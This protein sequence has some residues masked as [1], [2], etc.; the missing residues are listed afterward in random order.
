MTAEP[1][2]RSNFT[3]L[4]LYPQALSPAQVYLLSLSL[5]ALSQKRFVKLFSCS[6]LKEV[7]VGAESAAVPP[8]LLYLI[9]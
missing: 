4:I 6:G 3:V 9:M 8:T 2:L 5:N 7:E 1:I